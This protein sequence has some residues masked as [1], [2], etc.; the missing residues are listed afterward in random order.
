MRKPGEAS[1]DER[2]NVSRQILLLLEEMKFDVRERVTIL[3]TAFAEIW[4]DEDLPIE[5]FDVLISAVRKTIVDKV[6]ED[7]PS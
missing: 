5:L 2:V 7:K 6:V 1:S 4:E 3:M